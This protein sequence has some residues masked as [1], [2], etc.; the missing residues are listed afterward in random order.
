MEK[1]IITYVKN[2]LCWSPLVMEVKCANCSDYFSLDTVKKDGKGYYCRKCFNLIKS[3]PN[4]RRN[5]EIKCPVCGKVLT[6]YDTKVQDGGQSY[7]P[8]CY[9][10]KTLADQHLETAHKNKVD[11]K[12][13]LG[14]PPSSGVTSARDADKL[15]ECMH[16]G[17]VVTIDRLVEGKD[18]KVRCQ[19]CGKALPIRFRGTWKV[20]NEDR[21][22]KRELKNEDYSATAQLFKC[23][24]DPCRVKII[25]ML[26]DHE[27]CVFEFVDM[28]GFQYSAVSYHLKM[29]KELGMVKAYE[30]GNFMVYSLTDKGEAVHE[31]IQKSK[32]L[33]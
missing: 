1:H 27:L 6:P 11:T 25:E 23:L 10:K 19:K 33:T 4:A 26:S 17:M 2:M 20:K 29:L 30:R 24:G 15:I 22:E 31:F 16:C 12:T 18:G 7:C 28:L 5:R 32:G 14:F 8:V 13:M 9:G 21:G 3:D